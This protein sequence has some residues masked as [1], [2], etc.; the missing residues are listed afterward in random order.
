MKPN[1]NFTWMDHRFWAVVKL[2][3]ESIGYSER[4]KGRK[5][6]A[7]MKLYKM[8]DILNAH[9]KL[10]IPI[11]YCFDGDSKPKEIAYM[12][13]EYLNYRSEIIQNYVASQLLNREKA[14][15]EF[16]QLQLK[17]K[18]SKMKTQMN[19]Q[20]GEKSHPSY[21]VNMVN[22]VAESVFWFGNFD[23]NPMTL[24][25]VTDEIWPLRSLC[26][27]MDWAFPSTLKPKILWEVKEYYWTTTFGSRIA[28]GVYETMLVGEELKQL[29]DA[30]GIKIHHV[31]FV[32]DYHTWWVLWR[33]YIC[34]LIDMLHI[35]YVDR[36]FF[37]K[38]VV[39]EWEKFLRETQ[40]LPS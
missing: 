19:K 33:S 27:R 4:G 14:L 12:I 30:H 5:G 15:H 20:K 32:D 23:A 29:K 8:D 13:L 24:G 16:T 34:R 22:L 2:V 9:K 6:V 26:R 37:G 18:G 35:G 3:S 38:E 7:S 31:L 28:D 11:L 10:G 21:L 25:I 36:I 1:S 39:T 17:Y 40:L